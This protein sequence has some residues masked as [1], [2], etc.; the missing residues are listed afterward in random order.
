MKTSSSVVFSRV[1][2]DEVGFPSIAKAIK[3]D[4]NSHE[5]LQYNGRPVPLPKWYVH[6][7]NAKLTR[8]SML[9]NFPPYL[10]MEAELHPASIL[11]ELRKREFYNKPQGKQAYST[12]VIRYSLML[13]FTSPQ[14]YRLFVTR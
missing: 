8:Y 10:A 1:V 2:Y 13:R 5:R 14:C 7:H 3:I 11:D 4:D 9:E 12:D 6:G